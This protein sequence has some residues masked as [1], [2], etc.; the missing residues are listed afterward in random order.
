MSPI[1]VRSFLRL[2][3]Y[4]ECKHVS[5]ARIETIPILFYSSIVYHVYHIFIVSLFGGIYSSLFARIFFYIYDYKANNT[6][7]EIRE[8]MG[9]MQWI[10]VCVC[11]HCTHNAECCHL[12][13]IKRIC[14]RQKYIRPKTHRMRQSETVKQKRIVWKQNE[15]QQRQ[16]EQ[17]RKNLHKMDKMRRNTTCEYNT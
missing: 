2:L 17:R 3:V 12:E 11:V 4:F 9:I 13:N 7:S 16:Q 15:Y 8:F 6:Y 1:L 10:S 14:T 5:L